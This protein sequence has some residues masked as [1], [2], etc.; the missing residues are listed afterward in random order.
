MAETI[1][2]GP[3]RVPG[4]RRKGDCA[5]YT[6]TVRRLRFDLPTGICARQRQLPVKGSRLQV[7]FGPDVYRSRP[8]PT[9]DSHG[10][11]AADSPQLPAVPSSVAL[12]PRHGSKDS[13]CMCA[14]RHGWFVIGADGRLQDLPHPPNRLH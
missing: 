5:D 14:S 10:V 1:S 3:R 11:R 12:T 6:A 9:I 2:Y 4:V 7:I 13:R 8:T